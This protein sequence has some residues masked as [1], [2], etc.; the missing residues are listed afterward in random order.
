MFITD[1]EKNKIALSSAMA[2][3]N[4]PSRA[5][6]K[7]DQ[8]KKALY[9]PIKKLIEYL[10]EKLKEYDK[11]AFAK[12][13]A[14]T[15]GTEWVEIDGEHNPFKLSIK[16]YNKDKEEISESVI[17]FPLEKLIVSGEYK[18]EDKTIILNLKDGNKVVI[19]VAKMTEGLARS[20]T[21][22]STIV[23]SWED[24]ID[25]V[26]P[27]IINLRLYNANGEKIS[28]SSID[29]PLEQLVVSGRYVEDK[30][31][32]TLTLKDS[33][34]IDIPVGDLVKDFASS[35]SVAAKIS[36]SWTGIENGE[37]P[38]KMKISLANNNNVILSECVIDIP[39]GKSIVSGSYDED[40]ESLVLLFKDGTTASVPVSKLVEDM[41]SKSEV[42][43]RAIK[44]NTYINTE[45]SYLKNIPENSA[46]YA[47]ISRLGGMTR[48]STNL[49]NSNGFK[50]RNGYI[51]NGNFYATS[52]YIFY[53][54]PI[55][56]NKTYTLTT[57]SDHGFYY[58]E[59]WF[60]N[61]DKTLIGY[62]TLG[63]NNYG[64]SFSGGYNSNYFKKAVFTTPTNCKYV[65]VSFY[66]SHFTDKWIMLN[67][68]STA[69]PYEPYFEGLR[70]SKVTEVKS[71]G[72]NLL[73][74]S[75]VYGSYS[76]ATLVS[77]DGRECYK[78][79]T[80]ISHFVAPIEFK[81]NTQ[82]TLTFKYCSVRKNTEALNYDRLF[83]FNYTDGTQSTLNNTAD[84]TWRTY[85][86]TSTK[87]KTIKSI[88]VFNHEWRIDNY[89]DINTFM[90]VE[91]TDIPDEY[92]PY[93]EH[94]VKIPEAI[95]QDAVV[96]QTEA[97][98][99]ARLNNNNSY[100]SWASALYDAENDRILTAYSSGSSHAYGNKAI[101]VAEYKGGNVTY[102]LVR[103]SISIAQSI[104][105]VKY[106]NK[107]LVFVG[108]AEEVSGN[109][110]QVFMYESTDLINWTYTDISATFLHSTVRSR[111]VG[112]GNV[113]N[114]GGRLMGMVSYVD[115]N[116][117]GWSLVYVTYSDDG[118][119]TWKVKP[120]AINKV[121]GVDVRP[122][123]CASEGAFI[124]IDNTIITLARKG[125]NNEY[126]VDK[127]L[128]FSY[129][130][131]NGENWSD[132]VDAGNIIDA[133]NSNLSI[134]E[135]DEDNIIVLFASRRQGNAGIFYSITPKANALQNN[136]TPPVKLLDGISTSDFGYPFI[137]NTSDGLDFV[138]YLGPDQYNASVYLYKFPMGTT[139]ISGIEGYG[140]SNPD[141]PEEYN[142]IDFENK[143]FI[144]CGHIDDNGKWVAY[145]TPQETDISNLLTDDNLIPVEGGGTIT[146][147][148]EYKHNVP[149]K[150]VFHLNNN[151]EISATRFIGDLEGASHTA[152][153]DAT[154][155]DIAL[156]FDKL[157]AKIA[158][159]EARI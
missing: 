101:Y 80:D 88:G 5:G 48:R 145:E 144:A 25:G 134:A 132:F 126:N 156:T 62:D 2:L 123:T 96:K 73:K 66:K 51:A 124:R 64:T 115:A 136:F 68:G 59:I 17:D 146:F 137:F 61:D 4:D 86:L 131:D 112:L 56:E 138:Y 94:T 109:T 12:A 155:R 38:F 89:V 159:L 18:E 143:K 16:L 35:S 152:L 87:G 46:K 47:R 98:E 127:P 37:N 70:D 82:Y 125:I 110:N 122:L 21:T 84:D 158:E 141:N 97:T 140:Q 7:P 41:A 65:G 79:T 149:S 34:E 92:I 76:K 104:G 148:N 106:N 27:F 63:L 102:H 153:Y 29:L 14:S 71:V 13:S 26:N 150:V 99:I 105:I 93:T 147:E 113:H 157:L 60:C 58:R 52:D 103:S 100:E 133:N 74:A 39:L 28:E 117:D 142:Y 118:G 9:A 120:S 95:W 43:K 55:L 85:T 24:M 151:E 57:S 3:P 69:L 49:F 36:A 83:V 1:E 81:E 33:S 135:Y 32:I 54:I 44:S 15:I 67:E 90:F 40:T 121:N 119:Y 111:N 75:D 31:C 10:N 114:I 50:T 6:M 53:Y 11:L 128:L 77:K 154:G 129:S 8:I 78:F 23:A 19:E 139:T 22:A 72:K 130:T 91:G 42:D 107:Y 20:Q 30:Q 108:S 45:I 116:E